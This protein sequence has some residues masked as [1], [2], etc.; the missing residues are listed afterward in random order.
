MLGKRWFVL[1]ENEKNN[2][3]RLL[4]HDRHPQRNTVF[5]FDSIQIS[6]QLGESWMMPWFAQ[7]S[8]N[9][10][11]CDDVRAFDKVCASVE[12]MNQVAEGS[13]E[14]SVAKPAATEA[15]NASNGVRE[16]EGQEAG[17]PDE[18][19]GYLGN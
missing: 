11:S 18:V 2:H 12:K 17:E 6:Y 9:Q 4:V 19:E 7:M 14:H 15:G 1:P 8:T 16:E 5:I 3:W 13:G 10:L